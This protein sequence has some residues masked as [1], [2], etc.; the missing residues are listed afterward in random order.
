MR[1][2]TSSKVRSRRKRP[3][4]QVTDPFVKFLDRLAHHFT[5]G[6]RKAGGGV[7]QPGHGSVIE[8]K[9]DLNACHTNTLLPYCRET[10]S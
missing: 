2:I 7:L 6:Q 4:T 10:L 5:F 3:L 9:R 8:S 1:A